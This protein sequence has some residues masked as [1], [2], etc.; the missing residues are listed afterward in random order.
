MHVI[1]FVVLA[2]GFASFSFFPNKTRPLS[3]SINTAD[4]AYRLSGSSAASDSFAWALKGWINKIQARR[5]PN[6]RF[7][8]ICHT[9]HH[10]VI[11][12]YVGRVKTILKEVSDIQF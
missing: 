11:A 9:I 2:I 5:I 12:I 1:I 6:N 8:L 10:H 7:F 4:W 3:A